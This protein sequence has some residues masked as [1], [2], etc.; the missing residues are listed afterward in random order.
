MIV[1]R[2]KN[3]PPCCHAFDCVSALSK[4]EMKFLRH[5]SYGGSKHDLHNKYH[6]SHKVPWCEA[7][8][9]W[10]PNLPFYPHSSQPLALC[11]DSIGCTQGLCPPELLW[12]VVLG[13][14]A[15]NMLET[16]RYDDS[17]P[18][19]ERRQNERGNRLGL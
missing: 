17:L 1:C 15:S 6:T 10:V 13:V 7:E 3:C 16:I 14:T 8:V 12:L 2:G 18:S 5:L 11:E 4:I 19:C 9:F